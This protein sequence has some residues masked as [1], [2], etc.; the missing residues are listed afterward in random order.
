MKIIS[1]PFNW[2]TTWCCVAFALMVLLQ[3]LPITGVIL[4]M[5][6]APYWVG[7]MP[8][9]IA[10]AFLIDILTKKTSKVFLI[11]PFIPY[12]I[13]YVCFFLELNHIQKIESDLKAQNAIEI[14]KYNPEIHSL[15]MSGNMTDHYKIPVSYSP[16]PNFPEAHFSHRLATQDLA[17]RA[18]NTRDWIQI[19]SVRWYGFSANRFSSK[20]FNHISRLSMPEKPTK[21]ILEIKKQEV[22][23]KNKK[24]K[25]IKYSFILEDKVIGTAYSATYSA[26]PI[27]PKFIIGCAL[28]SSAPEWKCLTD[29][30]YQKKELDVFPNENNTKKYGNSIVAHML[31][32]EKY[33]EDELSNF[34]DDPDTIEIVNKLNKNKKNEKPEDFDEWGI[35]KDSLYQPNIGRNKGYPS[36]KGTIYTN[37]KGGAFYS[38]MKENTGKIVYLDIKGSN[39]TNGGKYSI[40]NYG[41]CKNRKNCSLRT[42]D[43]YIFKYENGK[44]FHSNNDG[45]FIGFFKVG[46]EIISENNY[47]K[48]DNDTRRVLTFIPKEKL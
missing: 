3:W 22:D 10:G 45:R 8:H 11:I 33:T 5:F 39:N 42:D 4:M 7:F 9:I 19:H 29:I 25:N 46:E 36:L 40:G 20:K 13:Y 35:R 1:N 32:I 15:I 38:F 17:Q 12:A 30:R 14:L 2:L 41:V 47:N 28:I 48:N 6:A 37:D 27:F 24:L 31:K 16:N 21:K 18:R 23:G 44:N 34:K 26:L 43:Y